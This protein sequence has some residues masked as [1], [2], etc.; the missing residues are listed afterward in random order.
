MVQKLKY[1]AK[2]KKKPR[3][4]KPNKL[5]S[6]INQ[7][8]PKHSESNHIQHDSFYSVKFLHFCDIK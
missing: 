4:P 6:W 7:I 3:F 5:I 1:Q 2:D 8:N